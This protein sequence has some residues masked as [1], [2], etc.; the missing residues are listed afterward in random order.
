MLYF[1][2]VVLI[3]KSYLKKGI[4]NSKLAKNSKTGSGFT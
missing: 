3:L 4:P 1:A 2:F